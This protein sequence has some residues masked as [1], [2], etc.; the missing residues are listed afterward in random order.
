MSK[1]IELIQRFR[2]YPAGARGMHVL[3]EGCEGDV[4]DLSAR[5]YRATAPL[6]FIDS[7]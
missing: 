1:D 6:S 3:G 2:T 7:S 4:H 5:A